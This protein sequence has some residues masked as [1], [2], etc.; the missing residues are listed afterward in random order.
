M[1]KKKSGIIG[2]IITVIILILLVFFSN[3]KLESFSFVENAFSTI[4]MPI[5]TGYTYLKNKVTGNSNFFDNMDELKAENEELKTNNSN[6]EQELRELEIIKAE[7]ET[8]KEYLG[9]TEKYSNYETIP[10]YIISKDISNYSSIFVI[11]AGKND[12][13][14]VNM[15]VIADEGLVR[16]RNISY[17]YNSKSS[18][19]NRLIKRSISNN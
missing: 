16:I 6:L 5:Q 3:L 11:N 18:N 13:I 4:I 15:T 17:R 19:N 10:A 9:L 1:Y 14:E 12:G 8:L 2:I 7:N